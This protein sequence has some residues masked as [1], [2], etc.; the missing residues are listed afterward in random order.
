MDLTAI[1]PMSLGIFCFLLIMIG[2][3]A[4]AGKPFVQYVNFAMYFDRFRLKEIHLYVY[5]CVIVF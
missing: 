5:S 3:K 2:V 1:C 4:V